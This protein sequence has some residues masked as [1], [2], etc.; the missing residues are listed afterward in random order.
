VEA[1][2][3]RGVQP[4]L[5]YALFLLPI[6]GGV[7][8]VLSRAW[9][10]LFRLLTGENRI[11]EWAQ[12]GM[13]VA[14]AALA[15][16]VALALRR[17]G[18]GWLALLYLLFAVATIFI[19]GEEIAWGQH[20]IGYDIPEA[21]E[22]ANEQLEATA[23]NIGPANDIFAAALA[24]AGLYG[25]AAPWILWL[26]ERGAT[27]GS[28]Q[29]LV[30]PP[31]FLTCAFAIVVVYRVA[32]W[33]IFQEDRYTVVKL[34]EWPEFCFALALVTFAWLSLRLARAPSETAAPTSARASS[35]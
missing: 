19:A 35:R 21:L 33:A 12:F 10:P 7:L 27:A 30:V 8:V 29:R 6:V 20:L 25:A 13:Y 1:E 32:R 31:L 11:L 9:K 23:H 3:D 4:R 18:P 17:R 5:A 26:R 15:L 16:C 22:E 14:T 24:A 34:Q 28:I 2:R